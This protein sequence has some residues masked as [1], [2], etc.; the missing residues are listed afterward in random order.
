MAATDVYK[1]FNEFWSGFGVPAFVQGHAEK[2]QKFPYITYTVSREAMFGQNINIGQVWTY[3][4]NYD[5]AAAI[6]ERIEKAV[7]EE[8]AVLALPGGKGAIRLH[9]GTP[10]I[11]RQPDPDGMVKALLV[12][13]VTTSYVL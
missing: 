6:A 3:S 12:N 9:R 10:F 4:P 13:V 2:G 1:L 5:Q 8:G 11:Q 7:P